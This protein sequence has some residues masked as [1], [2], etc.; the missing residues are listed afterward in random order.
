[1]SQ[2]TTEL[3]DYKDTATTVVQEVFSAMLGTEVAPVESFQIR[4]LS[5]PVVGAVY[6]AG[7][8]KGAVL[9]E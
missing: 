9:L 2:T 8:W 7:N 5:H 6:F 1:M 3:R 4:E